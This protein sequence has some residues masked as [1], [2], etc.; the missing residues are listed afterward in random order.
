MTEERGPV[1]IPEVIEPDEKLPPDLVLLRR[2]A[3][4]MDDAV[5]IPG[6]RQ[7]IGLDAVAGLIPGFGDIVT[8]AMSAWIIIGAMRHRVPA[9][10]IARM[11][12]NL[13]VDMI[14]GTIPVAGDVFDVLHQQN[15]RNMRLLMDHR[16]RQ[17]PPR[18]KREIAAAAILVI[19]AIAFMILGTMAAA[20]WAIYWITQQRLG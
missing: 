13:A 4:L 2:F 10:K 14:V 12:L 9:G 18:P 11:L 5:P 17:L 20:I 8:G 19:I 6:T 1:H 3:R 7:G 16:N 15:T